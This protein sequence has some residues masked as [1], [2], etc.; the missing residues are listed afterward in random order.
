MYNF[1]IGLT[2]YGFQIDHFDKTSLNKQIAFFKKKII[3]EILCWRSTGK[4]KMKHR[5]AD[6]QDDTI[7]SKVIL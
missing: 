1:I 7:N 6:T 2:L 3:F 5:M 4:K